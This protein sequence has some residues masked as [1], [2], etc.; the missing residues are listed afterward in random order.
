MVIYK[1]RI[2]WLYRQIKKL[3]FDQKTQNVPIQIL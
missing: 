3:S 1:V 2:K